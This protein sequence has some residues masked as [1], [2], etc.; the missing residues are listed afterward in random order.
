M[1][2]KEQEKILRDLKELITEILLNDFK[3]RKQRTVKKV[4]Q[5]QIINY[6]IVPDEND[7]DHLL[8]NNILISARVYVLFTEDSTSSD[9][10]ILKNQKPLSFRFNKDVDNYEVDKDTIA[11]YDAS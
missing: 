4:E 7:R 3:N 11:F 10:I 9:D 8:I 2:E 1:R 6:E 5:I